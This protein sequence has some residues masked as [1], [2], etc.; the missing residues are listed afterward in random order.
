MKRFF[1]RVRTHFDPEFL[2]PI[3]LLLFA[4][5][6]AYLIFQATAGI[7]YD[8]DHHLAQLAKQFIQGNLWLTPFDQ[9]KNDYVDYFG[10]LYLYFGPLPSILLM[11]FVFLF[12]SRFPQVLLG[13]SALAIA[14]FS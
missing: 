10:Y 12:D 13:I 1:H 4:I 5:Y 8:F 3:A 11:P 14:F 2:M 9:P 7:K 6:S